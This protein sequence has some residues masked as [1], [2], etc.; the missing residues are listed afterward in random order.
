MAQ[1]KKFNFWIDQ[2]LYDRLKEC[3]ERTR[4]P[5]NRQIEQALEKWFELQQ[6]PAPA[7]APEPTPQPVPAVEVIIRGPNPNGYCPH[8]LA[9]GHVCGQPGIARGGVNNTRCRCASGHVYEWASRLPGFE[10]A[11]DALAA[12]KAK[13]R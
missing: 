4:L 12:A 1:R 7:P 3:Q 9:P 11:E 8:E 2:A 6:Q 13:P 5:I 10:T